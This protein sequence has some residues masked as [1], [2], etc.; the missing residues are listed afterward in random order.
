MSEFP[1]QVV[2]IALTRWNNIALYASCH[3]AKWSARPAEVQQIRDY[4]AG[5]LCRCGTYIRVRRAI[6]DA[7]VK[8]A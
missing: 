3:D 1:V 2:L 6:K 5:N 7:A 4:L 8:S